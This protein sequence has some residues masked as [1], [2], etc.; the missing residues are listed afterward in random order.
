MNKAQRLPQLVQT[1]K[2]AHF[3]ISLK[4]LSQQFNCSLKTTRRD[5][6]ELKV[7]RNAPWFILN[8]A[9]YF[10]ASHAHGIEM[11]GYWFDQKEIESLF[12]LNHIIEQLSP[13][14]LKQQLQPFQN[15]MND[16]LV[17]DQHLNPLTEKVKLIEIADRKTDPAVFETITQA[18]AENKQVTIQFWNRFKNQIIPRT[19]SPQQLVRYKD[20][21]IVDAYCHLRNALRSFSLEA[22]Q[23]IELL[24]TNSKPVS[25]KTIKDYFQSSYGIYAGK[26]TQ[27]A[28]VRFSPY[29]S[30]WVQYEQWHPQQTG[31][32]QP[33][34]FYHL[35][36]PYHEADE[37]I[38]DVLKYGEEAEVIAPAELRQ[39]VHQKLKKTLLHYSRDRFCP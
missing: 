24:E 39:Q 4:A 26:A 19:L 22:I 37:L 14:A 1:L 34:G 17:F 31:Q 25:K 2:N 38:Q 32:W 12:A 23:S 13:G 36:I 35:T 20:N 16:F 30:R 8:N 7:E 5:I 28:T 6:N 15:R 9:V 11:Q 29:V 33:D 3:P 18:L 27:V 10:D 21:W